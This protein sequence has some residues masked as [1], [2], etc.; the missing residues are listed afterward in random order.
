MTIECEEDEGCDWHEGKQAVGS[1][2]K[3]DEI[4]SSLRRMGR[5]QCAKDKDDADRTS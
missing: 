3:M 1:A 2:N 4:S 5:M